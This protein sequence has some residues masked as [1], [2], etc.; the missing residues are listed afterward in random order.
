MKVWLA[1][2]WNINTQIDNNWCYKTIMHCL[3][4]TKLDYGVQWGTILSKGQ[5][6]SEKQWIMTLTF[7]SLWCI[8]LWITV[9]NMRTEANYTSLP[10]VMHRYSWGIL[11]I[12]IMWKLHF[13]CKNWKTLSV[14][15]WIIFRDHISTMYQQYFQNLKG[16][17]WNLRS[18]IKTLI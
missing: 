17:L 2:K 15:K 5:C 12:Q 9:H 18:I 4:M 6:Y 13:V 3:N 11:K 1:L 14:Q 10:E 8:I 16:L 7:H